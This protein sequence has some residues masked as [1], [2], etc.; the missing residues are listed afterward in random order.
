M[1]VN[2][3]IYSAGYSGLLYD[4]VTTYVY[5]SDLFGKSVS[6]FL[7]YF[8]NPNKTV[9]YSVSPTNFYSPRKLALDCEGRLYLVDQFNVVQINDWPTM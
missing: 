1:E 9:T 8:S 2:S 5:A 7:D 3:S 4:T 6:L